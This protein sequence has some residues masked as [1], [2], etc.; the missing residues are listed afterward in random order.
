MV[1]KE[2]GHLWHWWSHCQPALYCWTH[3][4]LPQSG[5]WSFPWPLVST[6]GKQWSICEW[7][8]VLRC[9]RGC[10]RECVKGSYVNEIRS[11]TFSNSYRFI[12]VVSPFSFHFLK[13]T[14]TN[15][16]VT[17]D[18]LICLYFDEIAYITAYGFVFEITSLDSIVLTSRPY[19]DVLWGRTT[20]EIDI[21]HLV[22][23]AE[24]IN[25]VLIKTMSVDKLCE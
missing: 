16:V 4:I 17:R 14:E 11:R 23:I 13:W 8:W 9:V 6:C 12:P 5:R 19:V 21:S 22:L 25:D 3:W 24:H 15:D 2:G 10:E 1:D 7:G 18:H 20:I